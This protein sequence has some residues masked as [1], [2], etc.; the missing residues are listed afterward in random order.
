MGAS[1]LTFDDLEQAAVLRDLPSSSPSVARSSAEECF[2]TLA[3]GVVQRVHPNKLNEHNF[4][5]RPTTFLQHNQVQDWLYNNC[6]RLHWRWSFESW[7]EVF[8]RLLSAA[9]ECGSEEY[10]FL[11]QKAKFLCRTITAEGM[12]PDNNTVEKTVT[13]VNQ[14]KIRMNSL[15]TKISGYDN[16]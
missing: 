12:K 9:F 15:G 11:N 3:W 2:E 4:G 13:N 6:Q 8:G 5:L 1:L 7:T 14:Q 10:E 16:H